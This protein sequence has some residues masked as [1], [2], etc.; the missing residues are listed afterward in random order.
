MKITI[1]V[2]FNSS[3]PKFEKVSNDKYI[4][5]I[6]EARTNSSEDFIKELLERKLGVMK[7]NI[8]LLSVSQD[9]DWSFHID[10]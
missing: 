10:G 7:K 4:L 9:G 8:S 6:P 2:R 3:Y 5:Y 1:K